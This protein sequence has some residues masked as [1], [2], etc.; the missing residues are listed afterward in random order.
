MPP[1]H[2]TDLTKVELH[3]GILSLNN[4]YRDSRENVEG[5]KRGKT[6]NIQR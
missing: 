4:K 2:Q 1:E 5:C 3:H 6:N